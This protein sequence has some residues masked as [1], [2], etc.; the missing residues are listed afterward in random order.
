MKV[1][2]D[3]NLSPDWAE[4]IRAA[5]IEAVHWSGVGAATAKDR[6]ILSWAGS[7]GYLLLTHDLDFSAILASTGSAGP[8]VI[9]IR[10]ESLA[11]AGLAPAII[12]TIERFSKLLKQGAILTLEPGRARVRLLPLKPDPE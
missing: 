9:Q 8:S 1:L 6:E 11:P 10:S 12:Q 3:M 2:V 7:R 5:G 4:T